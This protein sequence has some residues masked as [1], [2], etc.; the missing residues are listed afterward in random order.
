MALYLLQSH[1]GLVNINRA[2]S[3]ALEAA[4]VA[5]GMGQGNAQ[6]LSRKII[7]HR[8]F[9]S[10]DNGKSKEGFS[11]GP[12]SAPLEA[13]SELYDI[14]EMGNTPYRD[15]HRTF[16]VRAAANTLSLTVAPKHLKDA[17]QRFSG[18]NG[19]SAHTADPSS[20]PVTVS[21]V[22]RRGALTGQFNGIFATKTGG[23]LGDQLVESWRYDEP[24]SDD[25]GN[26][27]GNCSATFGPEF[28]RILNEF[29]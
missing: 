11:G 2:S 21:V 20:T 28:G 3:G 25:E 19:T 22:V 23:G 24:A 8:S 10:A 27:F 6:D 15:L 7:A 12:K 17:A 16:T 26:I 18:L 9:S 14:A 1:A 4:L 29:G 5:L 13:I